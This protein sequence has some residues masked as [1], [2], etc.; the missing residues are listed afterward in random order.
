MVV[1]PLVKVAVVHSQAEVTGVVVHDE[2]AAGAALVGE[3][4]EARVITERQ[5]RI[6]WIR[7]G[8]VLVG[9]SGDD[10]LHPALTHLSGE[11]WLWSKLEDRREAP[12]NPD[13]SRHVDS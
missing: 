6:D 9:D 8:A 5:P 1:Q 2:Q 10:L 3:V 12:C 11:R 4:L 13:P 7:G